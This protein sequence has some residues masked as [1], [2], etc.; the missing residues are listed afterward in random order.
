MVIDTSAITAILFGEKEAEPMARAI[1]SDSRRLVSVFSVL[2]AGIVVE[3]K[4][5][6]AAGRELDLLLHRTHAEI[7]ALTGSQCEVARTAWRRYGKGSH[8][9]ELNIGNCC[10][11][12]LAKV[13]GE[14]LLFKGEGFAETDLTRVEY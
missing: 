14:P 6:E 7:I 2:E 1:A 4:K 10:A 11:Y 12:A 3:A 13:A 9:A 8:P 5:G